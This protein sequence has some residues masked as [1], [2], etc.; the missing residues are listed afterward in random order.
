MRRFQPHQ[1]MHMIGHSADRVRMT[2]EAADD[3][4]NIRV[5]TITLF[6]RK[7]GFPGSLC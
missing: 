3:A 4:T 7:P 6:G 1:H 2:P 5:Q